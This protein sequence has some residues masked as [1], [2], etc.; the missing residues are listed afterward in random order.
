MCTFRSGNFT[1]LGSEGVKSPTT[2][3]DNETEG[4]GK[5]D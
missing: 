3:E 5:E 2:T 4:A 1:D